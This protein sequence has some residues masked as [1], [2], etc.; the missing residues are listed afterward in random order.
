MAEGKKEMQGL[1]EK[2]AGGVPV[3]G[4][5][6]RDA[7]GMVQCETEPDRSAVVEDI[8]REFLQVDDIR[9]LSDDLGQMVKRVG[10]AFV[11]RRVGKA[12][13]GQIGRDHMV[14]P[15]QLRN[16]VAKHVRRGRKAMQQENG[17]CIFRAGLT[18]KDLVAVDGS[19]LRALLSDCPTTK[20]E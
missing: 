8:N 5:E 19:V 1:F 16:K 13:A 17:R 15:G 12:E 10:K 4:N 18:V 3:L 20:A 2:S 7:L 9:E 11:V 6:G 14:L